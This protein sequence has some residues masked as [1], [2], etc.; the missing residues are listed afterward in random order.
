M[1]C[2]YAEPWYLKAKKLWDYYAPLI[3]APDDPVR[4]F[5]KAYEPQG[6][7]VIAKG[8]LPRR[9]L[10]GTVD[11]AFIES[12]KPLPDDFDFAFWNCA[13]QDLQ[14]AYP[15][16][17]EVVDL[18][19]LCPHNASG[20]TKD[21]KANTILRFS[22]P[23]HT[24]YVLVRYENGVMLPMAVSLDTLVIE[25]EERRVSCVYRI[26]LP[27][28]PEIRILEARLIFNEQAKEVSRHG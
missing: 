18:F 2:G 10:C 19:N 15:D 23:G 7:G 12:E 5:R 9:K 26:L 4:E 3:E 20:T 24:P 21:D 11:K 22:L 28:E 14:I 25:P 1:G 27:L 16:G 17:N 6:L 13:H 8:C